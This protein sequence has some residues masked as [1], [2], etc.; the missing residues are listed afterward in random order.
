MVL[1]SYSLLGL[2][3]GGGVVFAFFLTS[4]S[5]SNSF[6]SSNCQLSLLHFLATWWKNLVM[7]FVTLPAPPPAFLYYF[8]FMSYCIMRFWQIRPARTWSHNPNLWTTWEKKPPQMKVSKN[9]SSLRLRNV[10]NGINRSR[11]LK[12]NV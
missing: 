3:F 8:L 6:I 9:M 1:V 11:L 10:R 7:I 5:L 4:N 12:R 2:F